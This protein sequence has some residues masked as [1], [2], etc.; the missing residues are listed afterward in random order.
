MTA[1]RQEQVGS[2][3]YGLTISSSISMAAS[4]C[5]KTVPNPFEKELRHTSFIL[6]LLN[7]MLRKTHSILTFADFPALLA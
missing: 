3:N 6:A 2:P 4:N 5:A 7:P 1:Q